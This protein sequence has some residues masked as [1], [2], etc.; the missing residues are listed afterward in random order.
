M[1]PPKLGRYEIVDEIGKGAM[2]VVYLARDPLIGRLVALKTFRIGYS[3]RDQEL[4]QFRIRFMREAQSAGILS[5]PNI[6]T[7]H[8]VVEQTEEGLAFIAMEYVRG[9]TLKA[10]LQSD[11]PMS[12]AFIVDLVSQIAEALDYAHA[13]RVIHRDVKPANILITA[14]NKV[15]ITDF[16]IARLDT[17][18]LTQEGQLLGTP[19]YMAPEQIQG[20]DIDHRADLFALGVVL[21]EMLT[22]H[23]PFQGENLTVVSHRIVYDHFTPPKE[24]AKDLPPG[25]EQVLDRALDKDPARRYQRAKDM[26]D[27]LRR[28]LS[29]ARDDLNETLSIA[30]WAPGTQPPHATPPGGVTMVSPAAA[31]PPS[32]VAA[33]PA[34]PPA[35]KKPRQP[36]SPRRLFLSAGVAA[37]VA[38]LAA[39]AILLGIS[40]SGGSEK[41]P[42]A[43]PVQ[44][45]AGTRYA[46][47]LKRG[48]AY[49]DTLKYPEA[50]QAFKQALPLAPEAEKAR[51]QLMIEDSEE[52]LANFFAN[53]SRAEQIVIHM[54]EARLAM[55]D[56]RFEDA[57]VATDAVL[58][59]EPAHAEAIQVRADAQK[60]LA[61]LRQQRK[62]RTTPGQQP[63]PGEQ[64]ATATPQPVPNPTPSETVAAAPLFTKVRINLHSEG[65]EVT[66]Q[67]LIKRKAIFSQT[68]RG[69]RAGILRK[70]APFDA[71]EVVEVPVGSTDLQVYVTPRNKAAKFSAQAGYFRAGE[72]RILDIQVADSGQVS[73]NL[74]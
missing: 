46:L 40:W 22:R 71:S 18:N 34:A 62:P 61:K 52:R 17:S 57:T 4:E 45:V 6:V 3:I 39:A 59:L 28:M 68:F 42:A 37:V 33:R 65:P 8:D 56:S 36:M 7:I 23:K 35:P 14:D 29:A 67:V 69:K 43:D 64:I 74:N 1:T 51:V 5:H 26:A 12:L 30:S 16:G 25:V 24:Y 49:R 72:T 48:E 54:I 38:I 60:G 41:P 53:Q 55:Q 63:P 47:L 50:I 21:Y 9:T 58:A 11:Q 66:V 27:D 13:H 31:V 2:G 15:K 19:N 20:K 70:A 73:V 44:D 10:L 32:A